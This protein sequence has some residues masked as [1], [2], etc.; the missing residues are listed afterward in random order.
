MKSRIEELRANGVTRLLNETAKRLD[1]EFKV[2]YNLY[3]DEVLIRIKMCDNAS[4]FANYASDKILD[5]ELARS[6]RFTY[7]K[8]RL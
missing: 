3:D 5:D 7:P 8:H 6:V 2:K 1:V 4:A